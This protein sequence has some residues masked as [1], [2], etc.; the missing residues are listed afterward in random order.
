VVLSFNKRYLLLYRLSTIVYKIISRRI[1][2][3]RDQVY[4]DDEGTALG[5]SIAATPLL[6]IAYECPYTSVPRA[7]G[8]WCPMFEFGETQ[9][10]SKDN[11]GV[12][13]TV[14][15]QNVGLRCGD[16]KKRFEYKSEAPLTIPPRT[17]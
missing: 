12:A 11:E 3:P 5:E 10:I 7:C 9:S 1:E 14:Y 2:M 13:T 17:P 4:K 8:S 6:S 15:K 16:G